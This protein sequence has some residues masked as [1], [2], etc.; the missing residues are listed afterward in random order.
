MALRHATCWAGLA[1]LVFIKFRDEQLNSINK[2]A[3]PQILLSNK[4]Y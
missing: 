3:D 4:Q 1:N 2:C